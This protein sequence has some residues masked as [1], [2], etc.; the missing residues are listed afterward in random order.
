MVDRVGLYRLISFL[1]EDV[2]RAEKGTKKGEIKEDYKL[3]L[4]ELTKEL[5]K[6]EIKED[7]NKKVEKIKELIEKGEYKPADEN[8]VKALKDFFT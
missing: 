2:K 3:T 4:S 6:E 1:S 5:S 7:T 8:I